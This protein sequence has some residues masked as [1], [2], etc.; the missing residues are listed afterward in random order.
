MKSAPIMIVA[1][2]LGASASATAQQAPVPAPAQQPVQFPVRLTAAALLDLCRQN[3]GSCIAYTL[4]AADA[5]AA[6]EAYAGRPAQFCVPEGTTNARMTQ[7]VFDYIRANPD[8]GNLSAGMVVVVALI[9]AFPC[10]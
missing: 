4:G 10:G 2:L 5:F 9:G 7:A 3:Q 8:R 1:A 6:A